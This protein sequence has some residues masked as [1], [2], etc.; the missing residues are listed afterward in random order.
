MAQHS[1]NIENDFAGPVLANMNAALAAAKS[2]SSGP[3]AP[4][5]PV[6]YQEWI[7]SN[8]DHLMVFDGSQW[9]DKG[10]LF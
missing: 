8:N 5:Q 7:N 1:F 9:V 2:R 10:S 6:K 3:S 4:P